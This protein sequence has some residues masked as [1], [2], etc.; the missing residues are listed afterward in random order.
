MDTTIQLELDFL[1]KISVELSIIQHRGIFD[2][3]ILLDD[4][5]PITRTGYAA[6]VRIA[7]NFIP[8]GY[9]IIFY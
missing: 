7:C 1:I 4:E 2:I 9:Q 8:T 6:K 3:C 5:P